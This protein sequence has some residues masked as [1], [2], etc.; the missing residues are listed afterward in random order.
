MITGTST[1]L[2]D[3]WRPC[4]SNAY[5]VQEVGGA[6]TLLLGAGPGSRTGV[7]CQAMLRRSRGLTPRWTH[8]H[9]TIS[10][11]STLVCPGQHPTSGKG[12][13]TRPVVVG[14]PVLVP[15][16]SERDRATAVAALTDILTELS[17]G[18][19]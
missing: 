8:R 18:Q 11:L 15:N 3:K 12:S 5:A 10:G 16:L 9:M 1:S 6:T 19:R 2:A 17:F 4:R 7:R 14:P 13:R